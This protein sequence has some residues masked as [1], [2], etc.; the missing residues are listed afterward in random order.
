M[1]VCDCLADTPIPG[2]ARCLTCGTVENLPELSQA[3]VAWYRPTSEEF[4]HPWQ[5]MKTMP[6]ALGKG[7]LAGRV[8][9]KLRGSHKAAQ[10]A[11]DAV[12]DSITEALKEGNAVT[13]TGFGSFDVRQIAARRVRA[14]R[15]K[16]KG[17]FVEVPA[18]K[19]AGF[20]A[21]T[22]LARAVTGQEPARSRR[23]ATAGQSERSVRTAGRSG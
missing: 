8:A 21:G 23:T 1:A 19:R 7:D 11:L 4:S 14:I 17:E 18:H 12:L 15:G 13:L 2:L 10:E 20:R 6:Q 9:S 22:E 16:Q 3:T 5:E